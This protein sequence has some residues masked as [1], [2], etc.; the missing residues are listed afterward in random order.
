MKILVV[1]R[2]VYFYKY[3]LLENLNRSDNADI[4]NVKNNE[5]LFDRKP[6]I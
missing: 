5:N 2:S 3:K 1:K 6:K 4:S